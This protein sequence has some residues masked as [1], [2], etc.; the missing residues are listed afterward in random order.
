MPAK[1]RSKRSTPEIS[2]IRRCTWPAVFVVAL[3]LSEAPFAYSFQSAN[4]E[5]ALSGTENPPPPSI[6]VSAIAQS[7]NCERI[8]DLEQ[9][10]E[11]PESHK[12]ITP[13]EGPEQSKPLGASG[14]ARLAFRNFSDPFN[15]AGTAIDSAISNATS[16]SSS[17]FGTGWSGFGRRFGMSMADA[18]VGEF[19]STFLV[20]TLAHQDPHYHRNPNAST[21]KRI[22]YAL[23]RV[24]V[25]RSDSGEA[26]FN[27]SEFAG[28]TASALVETTYN[29]D[30]NDPE[31][32]TN[33]I[34][35]SIASD[36]AWNL[37]SEFLPDLAGHVNPKFVFLRRLA[38][39]AA[40]QH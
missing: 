6:P 30:H 23:S 37:M 4:G 27:V 36:A 31:A 40:E 2:V 10:L 8:A 15:I 20:S 24:V 29:F 18:G 7:D 26:M 3:A 28:T 14:K 12:K 1:N 22:L 11:E 13:I 17:A 16:N 5:L 9:Q 25:A 32:V 21:G 19:F 35:V 38:E 34:L 33:R 39:R